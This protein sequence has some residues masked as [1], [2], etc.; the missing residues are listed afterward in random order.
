MWQTSVTVRLVAR[1]RSWARSTRRCETYAAGVTPYVARNSRWKWN[2]L[3][4]ATPARVS[5]SSGSA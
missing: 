3:I 5:R 2:L 4:P 1:S